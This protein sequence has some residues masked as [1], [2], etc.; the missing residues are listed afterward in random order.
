MADLERIGC[1]AGGCCK[2]ADDLVTQRTWRAAVSYL[3]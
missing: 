3:T 1:P 2:V